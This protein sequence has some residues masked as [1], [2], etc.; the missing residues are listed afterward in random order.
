VLYLSIII[1]AGTFSLSSA[2]AKLGW[3]QGMVVLLGLC[4]LHYGL[5][6]LVAC[7]PQM[8]GRNIEHYGGMGR[9]CL[10][11]RLGNA[12]LVCSIVAWWTACTFQLCAL[13]TNLEAWHNLG[14]G[15]QWLTGSAAR[16]FCGLPCLAFIWRTRG[17]KMIKVSRI[18]MKAMM[19]VAVIEVSCAVCH[20]LYGLLCAAP[21][22]VVAWRSWTPEENRQVGF[23]HGVMDMI[24]AFCGVGFLPYAIADMLHP[25][26]A[27]KVITT[28]AAKVSVIYCVVGT[29]SYL[30][31]GD[32]LLDETPIKRMIAMGMP[33]SIFASIMS[34]LFY[35]KALCA[36]PLFFWPLLREMEM[37]IPWREL[38]C[39]ELRL[40]WAL[41]WQRRLGAAVRVTAALLT[42]VPLML[43]DF[44]VVW[45]IFTRVATCIIVVAQLL[46]PA[47]FITKGIRV[48]WKRLRDDREMA[49]AEEY[50]GPWR[51]CRR[52]ALSVTSRQ[53]QTPHATIEYF[54]GSA[55]AH[56]VASG[57][58]AAISAFIA[59]VLIWV[60]V[61]ELFD[62]WQCQ[63]YRR[64]T[65][66][67]AAAEAAVA[68][69]A[70]NATAAP[71]QGLAA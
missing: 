64:H 45:G 36:Y 30:G 67:T 9:M 7:L 5:A 56:F 48:H 57:A 53:F 20:L 60:Q 69:F 40:P 41:T 16:A 27:K 70:V 4:A 25:E 46:A 26:N 35:I 65:P 29:V 66:M 15:Y 18:S 6:S 1:G 47:A 44:P 28:A 11:N 43:K 50:A 8:L 68:A 71:G 59:L 62:S 22:H 39:L 51:P 33:Y 32:D 19:T 14:G 34:F 63:R 55:R 24:M 61:M 49:E 38:P 17:I 54:G 42:L 13:D 58:V 10:S 31:W 12:F 3:L 2:V 21:V 37:V 52:R 23:L